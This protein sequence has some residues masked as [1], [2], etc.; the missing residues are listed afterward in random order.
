[1]LLLG[2]NYIKLKAVLCMSWEQVE[3]KIS[4]SNLK[5][6]CQN[7]N[8]CDS[9]QFSLLSWLSFHTFVAFGSVYFS[10][11]LPSLYLVNKDLALKFSSC[12]ISSR[13][14]SL[15]QSL[16]LCQRTLLFC[17]LKIDCMILA[18]DS[19]PMALDLSLY[20]LMSITSR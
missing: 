19:Y 7:M 3:K 10:S 11:F 2:Y 8:N 14:T 9:Y 20:W 1:M 5:Q 17:V 12:F 4:M 13:K 18:Q 15:L 16:I 6:T